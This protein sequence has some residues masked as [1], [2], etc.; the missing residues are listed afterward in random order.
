MGEILGG[1]KLH[2]IDLYDKIT[3]YKN[4]FPEYKSLLSL[5]EETDSNLIDALPRDWAEPGCFFKNINKSDVDKKLFPEDVAQE[6]L[7]KLIDT[8]EDCL[9]DFQSRHGFTLNRDRYAPLELRKYE[10][11]ANLSWHS[12]FSPE[13]DVYYSVTMNTYL[14]SNYE[15][16]EISFKL[17]FDENNETEELFTYKPEA[18]DILL[19]PSGSPYLHRVSK[20]LGG[21]RFFTNTMIIEKEAP[22]WQLKGEYID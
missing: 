15:G 2:S 13:M 18:G 16:G 1:M 4:W 8:Y 3:L 22:T 9:I 10:K 5:Y 17:W 12:D 14:N 7:S 20:L 19:F 21:E 11:D 6:T